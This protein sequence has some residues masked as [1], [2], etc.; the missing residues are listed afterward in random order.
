MKEL[1]SRH[2]IDI[3][4]DKLI[5]ELFP[6]DPDPTHYYGRIGEER[7]G[8]YSRGLTSQE[9]DALRAR[10]EAGEKLTEV[11]LGCIYLTIREPGQGIYQ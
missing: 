8:K 10:Q 9:Y 1:S 2:K 4:F 7:L 6:E 5:E 3:E 11:E